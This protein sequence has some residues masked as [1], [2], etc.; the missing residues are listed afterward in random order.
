VVVLN[1]VQHVGLIAINLVYPLLLFRLTDTSLQQT[2][3]LLA[4]G[5]L[6]LG[7]GTLI[8]VLRL[9]PVGSGYMLP[10]T[11]TASFFAPSLLAAKLGG[12]PLVFG[13]TIFGGTAGDGAGAAAEQD[14][15]DISFGDFRAGDLHDR[16][17]R[18][19]SP[20]CVRCSGSRRRRSPARN[21]WSRA[22]RWRRWIGFNVWGKG[23]V[24]MLV[25]A[26]RTG[27]PAMSW[28]R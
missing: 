28:R 10:S 9:G 6:V 5:M 3:N 19:V 27:W 16:G 15:G 25:R 12:L 1:G 13:M 18:R 7:V 4:I 24:R 14:A 26:A 23:I 11:F 20:A 22:P 8:Q 17:F 2:A 21:G